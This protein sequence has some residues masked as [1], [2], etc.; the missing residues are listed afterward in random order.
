MQASPGPLG[1]PGRGRLDRVSVNPVIRS[2]GTFK[3]P[4]TNGRFS[5]SL[6]HLKGDTIATPLKVILVVSARPNF[7][8]VAPILALMK[9]RQDVFSPVLVLSLIHISEPTRP[10]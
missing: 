9:A 7:M 4:R 6:G 3:L 2:V 5:T 8:K 10:Y 1:A